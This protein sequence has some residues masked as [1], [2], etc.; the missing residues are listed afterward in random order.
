MRCG[1]PSA[2][3]SKG[4]GYA[5]AQ[6]QAGS[7]RFEVARVGLQRI[8]GSSGLVVRQTS[9][10]SSTVW[11]VWT[12]PSWG[13]TKETGSVGLRQY[14]RPSSSRHAPLRRWMTSR[15]GGGTTASSAARADDRSTVHAR[16]SSARSTRDG[17]GFEGGNSTRQSTTKPPLGRIWPSS[18]SPSRPAFIEAVTDR[19]SR[20]SRA[21]TTTRS[22]AP[23]MASSCASTTRRCSTPSM[24]SERSS[25][26]LNCASRLRRNAT[27]Y[28][29]G[30][31]LSTVAPTW[32]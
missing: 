19:G 32:K 3:T 27:T 20:T 18:S 28:A 10:W 13:Q 21:P 26:N 12:V 17:G 7:R 8:S 30:G 29:P 1:H 5:M 2:R 9:W 6:A 23:T 11:S 22:H 31:T 24:Y 14:A 25:P 4:G 16:E 15:G